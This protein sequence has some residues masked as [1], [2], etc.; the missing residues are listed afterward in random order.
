[1]Q[2]AYDG[3]VVIDVFALEGEFVG[4]ASSF[5]AARKMQQEA[6]PLEWRDAY[7]G[8]GT[9]GQPL[10]HNDKL[11]PEQRTKMRKD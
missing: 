6:L 7:A 11:T 1:M 8:I 9:E 10:F 5:G 3:K 4:E 2:G